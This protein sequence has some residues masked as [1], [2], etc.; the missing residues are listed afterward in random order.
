MGSLYEPVPLF[1]DPS[2]NLS[3]CSVL[4]VT[5]NGCFPI[6]MAGLDSRLAKTQSRWFTAR[7]NPGG[8]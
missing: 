6:R 3:P 8:H 1:R 4:K 7:Q 5:R 2:M